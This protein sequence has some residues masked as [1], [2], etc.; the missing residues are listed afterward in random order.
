MAAPR[1]GPAVQNQMRNLLEALLAFV[2]CELEGCDHLKITFD[3]KNEDSPRPELVVKTKRIELE[4]LTAKYGKKL[5]DRQVR[6]S[7]NRL[8]D[9]LGILK[10]NRPGSKG[11]HERHFTLKLW[12]KDK[13][14]NL[15]Q[16]DQE[17]LNCKK[18]SQVS[19]A[20]LGKPSNVP[21]L[22]L[23][24]LLRSNE[25]NALKVLVLS[26][27]NQSIG[28]TGTA[29]RVGVHGMGGIGKS[30]LAAMLAQDEEVRRAFPDGVLWLTLGQEP[31]LTLRQLDLATM[32]GDGSPTFQDVQQGRVHLSKFL[33]DKAC[34]LILDDVWRVEHA[35][36]FMSLGQHCK[37]LLTTR[38]SGVVKALEAVEYQLGVLSDEQALALL[39]LWAGQHEETL[40]AEAHEVVQECGKLPLAL[41][42]IGAI[43]RGKTDRW[44]NVLYKLRNAD[45]EKIRHWF[46]DYP[47]PNLLKAI[48]VSVE[49]LELD[50]QTRY[51]DFAVFPEDTQIPEAVLQTFWE[52]E[53]LN[54]YDT[55]DVVDVLVERSLARRDPKGHLSLHDLQYDYV[56]KQAGD[57]PVLHDR[58]LNAYAAHC[59]KGWHTGPNDGYFFEHLTHHLKESGRKD[60][61]Y[62]LLTASPDW[63]DAK[64]MTCTGDAAYVADLNLAMDSFCDPLKPNQLLSLIRL[65]VARRVVHQRANRYYSDSYSP[66]LIWLGR[67]AEVL[68]Y[69]HLC[70]DASR[71]YACLANTYKTLREKGQVNLIL[72]DEVLEAAQSIKDSQHCIGSLAV[73][74]VEL[75]QA[76]DKDK[77]SVAFTE[78]RNVARQMDSS[79]HKAR[80]L[81]VLAQYLYQAGHKEEAIAVFADARETARKIDDCQR[82]VVL[83]DDL[84]TAQIEDCQWKGILLSELTT[85]LFLSGFKEEAGKVFS[86]AKEVAEVTEKEVNELKRLSVLLEQQG[87]QA[88]LDP[89]LT[90]VKNFLQ[91][92]HQAWVQLQLAQSLAVMERFTEARELAEKIEEGREQL[93][94]LSTV[95]L[96]LVR[97]K[98]F[99][100]AEDVAREVREDLERVHLLSE[101][102]SALAQAGNKSKSDE[103]FTEVREVAEKN[104]EDGQQ[105]SAALNFIV[106]ALAQA[107]HFSEAEN[108]AGKIEHQQ[109]RAAALMS[110]AKALAQAGHFTEAKGITE[111][112]EDYQQKAEA[113]AQLS[114]ALA[115]ASHQTDARAAL[116]K[117]RGIPQEVK[118][119]FQWGGVLRVLA[120]AL[121]QAGF[122]TEARAVFDK[123]RDFIQAIEDG[124]GRIMALS[125]LAI[126]LAQAKCF[127]EAEL[128]AQGIQEHRPRVE[129]MSEL[130]IGLAQAG[131]F[132]KA[133]E[134]A[135]VIEDGQLRA[136][137][138]GQL[139]VA[140]AQAERRDRASLVFTEVKNITQTVGGGLL[141][142][143]QVLKT[144]V[145]ALAQTG[146]FSEAEKIAS[147]IQ[148]HAPRAEALSEVAAALAQAGHF[149]E[150]E[151]IIWKVEKDWLRAWALK[152]LAT[153][154]ART[155]LELEASAA[156]AKARQEAENIREDWRQSKALSEL[157]T[158]LVQAGC[159]VEASKVFDKAKD[160]A[161]ATIYCFYHPNGQ[162]RDSR[163][164]EVLRWLSEALGQ[165]GQF[166][167]ALAT[168]S[169]TEAS[170]AYSSQEL[171]QFLCILANWVAAF[172]T[173][174]PGLSVAILRES[175]QI[176]GWVH[177]V[178]QEIYK[179]FPAETIG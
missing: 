29:L 72:L 20:S 164:A 44:S 89:A 70:S 97:A 158:A 21:N 1:Y 146:D 161:L 51:L 42:M 151:K 114:I 65:H 124:A 92:E 6:E 133:E 174:E 75:T 5:D 18:A 82:Q 74:A 136:K 176:A 35:T 27:T 150:A 111:K 143:S 66:A 11:L 179:M 129:A 135:A 63:M 152:I 52:P 131:Q 2:S 122:I 120:T 123:A 31:A 16:F 109:Q 10:D 83:Q 49:S 17:W 159:E 162:N 13:E 41:A 3:W 37:L 98:R 141:P 171:N 127:T 147:D 175:V 117:A 88:L 153:E 58:L 19:V 156:F 4:K 48:Q 134:I 79:Q 54:E 168:F 47:Y 36:V 56:R 57:L 59:V 69:A 64:F 149:T 115:K 8:E 9:F 91:T 108:V 71:R 160:I 118:D 165:A 87:H 61:L 102:A 68:S 177:P 28:I 116:D 46:P 26:G 166:K 94:A 125:W 138:L 172:K 76:G 14:K 119:Y 110:L 25:L 7:L 78:A 148:E 144:L 137:A 84:V 140:L 99:P 22:P 112:I 40:P 85:T 113:L 45:L 12:S 173:I 103:I 33:E 39:A 101:L 86:E 80:A 154:L 126:D 73:V 163:Q 157:A 77:A 60:E 145:K 67:E 106:T 95:A 155:K 132:T 81:M 38:D 53:G 100:E 50:I 169:S 93:W 96:A 142:V 104:I 90:V 23:N 130:A 30:V 15:T 107:R 55:Q 167:E 128:I 170:T 178:W 121:A 43:V 105:Q 24:I 62:A 32:L 34:L 139:A